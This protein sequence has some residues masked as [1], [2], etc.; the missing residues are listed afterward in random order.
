MGASDGKV[1]PAKKIVDMGPD[2]DCFNIALLSEGFKEGEL[3]DFEKYC[4]DFITEFNKTSPFKDCTA[5]INFYRVNVS[6]TDSGA[7]DPNVPHPTIPTEPDICPGTNAKA[8]TYF[9]ATYCSDGQIRRL[10]GVN[11]AVLKQVL[12]KQVPNYHRALVIVNSSLYGGSGGTEATVSVHSNW[13][14]TALHELGHTFG[15]ADEYDHYEGCN[16]PKSYENHH[17][18]TEPGDPNATTRTKRHELK[19]R[20][21]VLPQTPIP[22]LKNSDCT[23]CRTQPNPQPAGTVGLYEGAHYRH[24]GAY[25]PSYHCMMRNLHDFC[26]V[27]AREIRRAL[28]PFMKA[29]DLA[30]TPWGYAQNPPKQPYWQT[31]DIWGDPMRGRAKNDLHIRVHNLGKASS[32]SFNVRV[33]YVPFTTMI[34]LKNEVLITTVGRPALAAGGDDQFTVNW[35]LTPPRHPA[36]FATYDHFCVIAE[37]QVAECNTSNNKAQNN[38]ANVAVKQ[39]GSPPPPLLFEIGNPWE[40]EADAELV[41]SSSDPRLTLSPIGFHPQEL[42]LA[43]RERRRV[44]VAL[45]LAPGVINGGDPMD[46]DFEITQLLDKQVVGGVSG[47]VS[48]VPGVH[49]IIG[50]PL[51]DQRPMVAALQT[52]L[53]LSDLVQR[54]EQIGE[55]PVLFEHLR[56]GYVGDA[57][58]EPG[59]S[60]TDRLSGS[61][62]YLTIPTSDD[63]LANLAE[64]I[65]ASLTE[66]GV[67]T[68]LCRPDPRRMHSQIQSMVEA[69]MTIM[70][71]KR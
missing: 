19:W 52:Q 31:P 37:I 10:I 60:D 26:P 5:R 43:A 7:D 1:Y 68:S 59:R 50:G 64:A 58:E 21:L 35:D 12:K 32:P 22:T 13:P 3:K 44:E 36:K 14:K 57:V 39:G 40:E 61:H 54:V 46:A 62:I 42:G 24:C 71:L 33:S 45:D 9:D 15:L 30:I 25:S 38:F 67:T 4:S 2:S 69:G 48:K 16:P 20:D 47:R 49:I 17:N 63:G 8:K 51:F 29:P 65:A 28:T 66:I 53:R 27:C 70:W 6:S 11:N 23:K 18:G 34:D 55:V 41:M 56:E